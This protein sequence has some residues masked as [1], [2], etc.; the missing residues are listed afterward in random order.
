M[1]FETEFR[2]FKKRKRERLNSL[3][4]RFVFVRA[5]N[6]KFMEL[7]LET[8]F[9]GGIYFIGCEKQIVYIGQSS[10]LGR[11][12][13]ESLGRIYH[14]IPDTNLPWSIGFSYTRG[15]MN[16]L[17]SSAIRKFAPSFNTSLPSKEKSQGTLPEITS[18]A[19][20][21][22]DQGDETGG[23]FI[24]ENQIKQAEAASLNPEP[25][26]LEGFSKRRPSKEIAAELQQKILKK[27]GDIEPQIWNEDRRKDLMRQNGVRLGSQLRYRIN[28]IENGDVIT[29][30]GEF[31]GIWDIDETGFFNFTPD[32]DKNPKITAPLVGALCAKISSWLLNQT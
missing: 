24:E 2:E 26:W 15:D 12:S 29:N 8:T 4:R 14:R 1:D 31:L 9:S 13:I 27:H 18:F 25:P 23:A 21:F 32:G 16:E 20:V 28:L 17:E 22:A 30:A 6:P 7:L 3:W 10:D 11:R 19:P 5:I